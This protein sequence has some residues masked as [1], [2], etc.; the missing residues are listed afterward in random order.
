MK[1]IL[2]ISWILLSVLEIFAHRDLKSGYIITNEDDTVY[3]LVDY[4]IEVYNSEN[5]YFRKEIKLS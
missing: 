3:G 2:I 5:C 1:K 4:Q